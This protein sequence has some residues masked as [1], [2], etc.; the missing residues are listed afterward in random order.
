MTS[1]PEFPVSVPDFSP[2]DEAPAVLRLLCDVSGRD[3]DTAALRRLFLDGLARLAGADRWTRALC[4][5]PAADRAPELAGFTHGGFSPEE[6]IRYIDA[7][8]HPDGAAW[9]EG[10]VRELLSSRRHRTMAPFR[11]DP[12][13]LF[14]SGPFAAAFAG[15]GVGAPLFSCRPVG[16]CGYGVVS[17]FRRH[18]APAFDRR[19]EALVHTALASV[20]ALHD[21]S[22]PE[23]YGAVIARLSRRERMVL[24]LIVEGGDSDSVAG[25]LGISKNTVN[26]YVRSL[27]QRFGVKSRARL[28]SL[29]TAVA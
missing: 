14:S 20:A 11:Y 1:H 12:E 7:V 6:F 27:Y 2:G 19:A 5:R 16:D 26:C 15:A 3:G 25:A 24:N 4:P 22:W 21:Q 13:D 9:T 23:N 10:L 17:F 28:L 18:G 8:N 29:H